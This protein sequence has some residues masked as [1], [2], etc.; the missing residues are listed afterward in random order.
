MPFPTPRDLSD[1]GI[2]PVPHTPALTGEFFTTEPPGKPL[3]TVSHTNIFAHMPSRLNPNHIRPVPPTL[4]H[5]C[6]LFP[7]PEPPGS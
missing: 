2:K 5:N 3:T 6:L 7:P 4:L 1:P